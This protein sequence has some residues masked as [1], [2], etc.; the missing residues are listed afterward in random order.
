MAWF[1]K[2]MVWF[3]IGV[4]WCGVVGELANQEA[5]AALAAWSPGDRDS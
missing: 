1:G 3:G 5:V 2:G 4:V